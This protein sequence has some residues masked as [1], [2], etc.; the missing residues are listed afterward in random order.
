MNQTDLFEIMKDW[1]VLNGDEDKKP[2]EAILS[3][4]WDNEI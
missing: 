1:L 4:A 3:T 2:V